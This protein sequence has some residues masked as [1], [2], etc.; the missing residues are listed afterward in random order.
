[1]P[2]QV[3]HRPMSIHRPTIVT[4]V[5]SARLIARLSRALRFRMVGIALLAGLTGCAPAIEPAHPLSASPSTPSPVAALPAADEPPPLP[6]R[7]PPS[8]APP[9]P[10]VAELPQLPYRGS[11]FLTAGP[12]P[13]AIPDRHSAISEPVPSAPDTEND[14][15]GLESDAIEYR[16]GQP[17]SRRDMPP[18]VV[19]HY[20]NDSCS[21]DIW[22]YRDLQS[23][24]LRALFTEVM[25][26]DRTDQRRQSCIKQLALQSASGTHPASADT[27]SPR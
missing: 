1:M 7:K 3:E 12:G 5:T 6:K 4:L 13:P 25:G 10:S 2:L 20:A 24:A 27:T 18:A 17:E 11:D 9:P 26:D 14:I 15:I 23:S 19:W 16:L 21:L 8:P 22:L